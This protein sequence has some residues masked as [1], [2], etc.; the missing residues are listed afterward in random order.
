MVSAHSSRVIGFLPE[1]YLAD[2]KTGRRATIWRMHG[3][4]R[5][6]RGTIES[7][8]PDIRALP[9]R[10]TP[11]RGQVVRGRRVILA[12]EGTHDLV[13]GETVRIRPAGPEWRDIQR[14]L[15]DLF[16]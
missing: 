1:V 8:A 7:I 5:Q 12:I 3:A 15:I 9:G 10:I 2:V 4:R 11:I 6:F 14:K 16:R 13:P